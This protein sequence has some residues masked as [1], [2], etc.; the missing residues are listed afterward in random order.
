MK[1]FS[2]LMTI[3]M[4]FYTFAQSPSISLKKLY[5]YTTS[6]PGLK[7]RTAEV[8]MANA[9]IKITKR[10]ILPQLEFHAQNTYGTYNGIAGSLFPLSGAFTISG[11][12]N[13][14]T[15]VD[16][17]VSAMAQ[18]DI[19]QFGAHRDHVKLAEIE[20]SKA[21]THFKL[22]D[23]QLKHQ[24]TDH[25]F[26]WNYAFYMYQ[27]ANREIDRNHILFKVSKARVN[28]GL[29]SAAD[30]LLIKASLK[31]AYAQ[32][33][34]WEG[35][36]QQTE[37]QILELSGISMAKS[38]ASPNFFLQVEEKKLA[39]NLAHPLLDLKNQE[40]E[41]LEVQRRNLTHQ[42][43]PTISALA[44]GMFRGVG[45]ENSPNP[46][47]D[48]YGLSTGN[49]LVGLGMTWKLDKFYSKSVKTQRN[50]YRQYMIAEERKVV[51]RHLEEQ[52]NSLLFQI[53]RS[54]QKIENQEAAY[55]SAQESY[56]LFVKRYE[57]GIIDLALLMQIQ[58]MLL[59]TES[60][61]IEA[62][63]DHWRFWNRLAYT[64]ADYTLFIN[65]FN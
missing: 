58:Q 6:Y 49:Y 15:A 16:A 26:Y 17:Q 30:S 50:K 65:T 40:K 24:L 14:G 60:A 54:N 13:E 28:S 5:K 22:E 2:L 11:L 21:K 32:K 51:E 19:I 18:W 12:G 27:W 31:Q 20:E 52:E 36:I 42:L 10:E 3:L 46:W 4:G 38:E 9:T 63:Y 43:F 34:K 25:Y 56:R 53:N 23:L 37:N 55:Q 44:G 61:R 48:S 41:G 35:E 29:D 64:R 45:Y 57:S 59:F 8:E 39:N 47:S 33:R 7:A 62:Y 1:Q